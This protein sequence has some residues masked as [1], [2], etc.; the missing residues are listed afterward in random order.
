MLPN[1]NSS[2]ISSSFP[3]FGTTPIVNPTMTQNTNTNILGSPSLFTPNTNTLQPP[4]P[5][6][7]PNNTNTMIGRQISYGNTP[8]P[9]NTGFS[10]PLPSSSNTN[11]VASP[12]VTT[13]TNNAS[14]INNAFNFNT[15]GMNNFSNFGIASTGSMNNLSMGM[16]MGGI[17]NKIVPPT[18]NSSAAISN[19]FGPSIPATGNM[20]MH[21]RPPITNIPNTMNTPMSPLGNGTHTPYSTPINS[22]N[23]ATNM[24]FMMGGGNNTNNMMMTM[25]TTL[26]TTGFN[27]TSIPNANTNT[28]IG[29]NN[30]GFDPFFGI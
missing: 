15:M 21:I 7:I 26:P 6:G 11:T 13:N 5:I 10:S 16:G 29:G 9:N 24:N 1:S 23:S 12:M 17:A 27:F 20:N 14:A 25:N 4:A 8:L 2:M 28:T 22:T 19:L 3:S 18:G 30:K